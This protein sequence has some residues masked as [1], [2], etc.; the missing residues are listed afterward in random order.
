MLVL[1]YRLASMVSEV[2]KCIRQINVTP[3]GLNPGSTRREL[4]D[5]YD[6]VSPEANLPWFSRADRLNILL[7]CPWLSRVNEGTQNE[8]GRFGS[9]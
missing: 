6:V 9:R 7:G 5:W 8:C 3:V 2:S 4:L 1:K